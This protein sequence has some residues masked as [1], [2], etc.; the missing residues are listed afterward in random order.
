MKTTLA[1]T[2]AATIALLAPGMIDI[3]PL[4]VWNASDSVPIGLYAVRPLT[5]PAVGDLVLVEPAPLLAKHLAE[6]EYLAAGVPMLKR[7]V[8]LGGQRICRSDGVIRID[9]KARA[10]VKTH[11]RA[12]RP[13]LRWSGCSRL[14]DGD[15]FFL[16]ANVPRSLDSRY[17]GP[18]ALDQIR[19]RAVPIWTSRGR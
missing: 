12:G 5:R 18:L 10:A 14:Q 11:D 7:V 4:V 3:A 16:N 2:T 19:G 8:A 13:L 17:F 15:V 9:G 1:L 6:R